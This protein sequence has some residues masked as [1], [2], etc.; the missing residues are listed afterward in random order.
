MLDMINRFVCDIAL[1]PQD[2]PSPGCSGFSTVIVMVAAVVVI[3][4]ACIIKAVHD[5]RRAEK[6]V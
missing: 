3:A 2:N 5:S 1:P 4:V 6:T